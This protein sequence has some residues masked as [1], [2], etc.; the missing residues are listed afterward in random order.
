[1]KQK[2]HQQKQHVCPSFD[3]ASIANYSNILIDC[4]HICR[5]ACLWCV[6]H[7]ICFGLPIYH[8]V[9]GQ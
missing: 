7:K 3:F 5:K 6:V 8:E 1:M 9:K 4:V 2:H